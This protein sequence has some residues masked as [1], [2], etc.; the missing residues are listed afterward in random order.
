MYPPN[1]KTVSGPKDSC[2]SPLF[3]LCFFFLF[4]S[5]PFSAVEF[6]SLT[7]HPNQDTLNVFSVLENV[8]ST[9]CQHPAQSPPIHAAREYKTI[10]STCPEYKTGNQRHKGASSMVTDCQ[11]EWLTIILY[12]KKKSASFLTVSPG[13]STDYQKCVISV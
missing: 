13:E 9:C 7:L 8:A 1:R 11:K 4:L 12:E 5:Q 2:A 6:Q 10:C 3:F